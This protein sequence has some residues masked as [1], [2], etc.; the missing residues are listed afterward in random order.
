M[1]IIQLNSYIFTFNYKWQ[2]VANYLILIRLLRLNYI[3]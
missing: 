1:K 2:F 3:V